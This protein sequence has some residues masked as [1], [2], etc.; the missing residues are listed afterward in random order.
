MKSDTIFSQSLAK[1]CIEEADLYSS[2]ESFFAKN[3]EVA[4]LL[5]AKLRMNY[6]NKTYIYGDPQS[7]E[8][9]LQH[10]ESDLIQ[11]DL[12]SSSGSE[13]T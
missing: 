1:H 8:H 10:V 13:G 12:D 6:E 2:K 7:S 5:P 3:V 4:T 11:E 9:L